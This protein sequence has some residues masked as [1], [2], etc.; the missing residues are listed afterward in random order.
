MKY[1]YIQP[2]IQVIK[3]QVQHLMQTSGEV[4]EGT[5]NDDDF[6]GLSREFDFSDD[7]IEE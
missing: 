4:L 7:L 5:T 1:I 2:T 6:E 3:M